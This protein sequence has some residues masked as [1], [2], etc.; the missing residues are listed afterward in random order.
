[1]PQTQRGQ[2][3]LRC[4]DPHGHN[5]VKRGQRVQRGQRG[6][7]ALCLARAVRSLMV[8]KRGA[9]GVPLCSN[10]ASTAKS[11][12]A[13]TVRAA[14]W[15]L[16]MLCSTC[17]MWCCDMQSMRAATPN[18]HNHH[19][20]SPHLQRSIDARPLTLPT[21]HPPQQ[22]QQRRRQPL[23]SGELAPCIQYLALRGGRDRAAAGHAVRVPSCMAPQHCADWH[24]WCD[25]KI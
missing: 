18:I 14:R 24:A 19:I 22:L 10:C 9:S 2:V 5:V 7:R 4:L 17:R 6:Q 21:K 3:V 23:D 11:R 13:G 12:L 20:D 16:A 1:M 15:V 25:K 8:A